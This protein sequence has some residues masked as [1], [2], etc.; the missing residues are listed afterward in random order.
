MVEKLPFVVLS[1]VASLV[2]MQ[3][4]RVG[5]PVLTYDELP[6]WPRVSNALISYGLYLRDFVWPA[7]LA[8]LYPHTFEAEPVRAAVSVAALLLVTIIALWFVRTRPYLLVGWL[9]FLGVLVPML[10]FVQIGAQARADRFT[11]IAQIGIFIAVVW[12]L[13]ELCARQRKAFIST[14][15]LTILAAFAIQTAAEVRYWS[16][17]VTL[18][19]RAIE[20]TG[21]NFY[22]RV[23]AGRAWARQGENVR[24]AE[25]FGVAVQIQSA[26]DDVWRDYGRVL[27]RLNHWEEAARALSEAAQLNPGSAEIRY[28]LAQSFA[29]LDQ[30]EAAIM[31]FKEAVRLNSKAI[32]YREALGQLLKKNG[33]DEEATQHLQEAE[34][35]RS[36]NRL[37]Y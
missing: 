29:G 36:A 6:L 24:A 17:S 9:W 11:Y 37:K 21:P 19:E 4:S 30:D 14:A 8:A 10:G 3:A 13:A 5:D 20:N 27:N 2:A 33:R 22:C 15:T 26:P 35:L 12:W 28:L 18:F 1:I 23:F 7:N 25:H 16:N 32:E 31:H 34:R